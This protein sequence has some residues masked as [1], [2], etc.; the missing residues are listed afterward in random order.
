M[1]LLKDGTRIFGTLYANTEVVIGSM[2]VASQINASFLQANSANVLA[3]AAF[4]KA[5]TDKT[6]LANSGF[7]VTLDENGRLL[8]PNSQSLY[9]GRNPGQNYIVL[10][11]NTATGMTGIQFYEGPNSAGAETFSE[12]KISF[13]T[14]VANTGYAWSFGKNGT[15][16]FPDNTGQ[17]TAFRGFGTDNVARSTANSAS[18]LAQAAFDVANT[19]VAVNADQYARDTA[20]TASANTI[21]TQGVDNTQN[22]NIASVNTFAGSAFDKANTAD[23]KAQ[24]AF[25]SANTNASNINVIQGVNTTQNTNISSV[26]TFA[27]AAYDKA[28]S[29][30]VLAQAAYDKANTSITSDQ[31]ARDTANNASANTIY[32]QGVDVTQNTNIT[33]VN[34]FAGSAYD[35]ANTADVKAQAAFDSA[36]TNASNI[37]I[38]QGIN[39]TQN[40][41]ITNVNTFAGSAYDKANTADVKSQSAYDKANTADVKSQSAYDKANTAAANTVYSQGVNDT[42][43]TSITFLNVYTQAAFDKA[44]TGV[45]SSVDQYARDKANSANVLAQAAFDVANTAASGS[46]DQFARDTANTAAANTVTLQGVNLTQNTAITI[47]QGVD[48]TQNTN[49]TNV[50]T[51]AGSAYDKANTA[52]V[53]AQAA[54]DKANTGVSSSVDQY[55]RDTANTASANTIYTQGVDVTQNTAISVIQGVDLTQNTNIGIIQGVDLTQ[56]AAISVIQGVDLTQNTSIS[57]IQGVDLTQNTRITSVENLVTSSYAHANAAFNQAN[58]GATFVNTGGTVS[59]NVTFTKDVSV[60]GNLY[61]LGNTVSVNTTSFSV[62]D[63]LI[64]LG[65]GNYDTDLLDI[66]FAGHYNDGTNAHAGFIR[67]ASQKEFY[68]FQGY[69]P[70]LSASNNVD[71]NDPSFSKA[72]LNAQVFKGN[73]IGSTAVVNGIELYNYTTSGFAKAN[74]VG[75]LAQASFDAANT[76]AANTVYGQGVNDTQNTN[77]TSVNT[78]AGSAYDKA[79]TADT[80]AQASF[81]V[82]NTNASDIAIIQ[83]VNTTQNT[84]ITNVNTFAGSAY[85]KAN[86]ADVKAQAAFDAANTGG[87][88]GGTLDQYARDKANTASANTIYTQG[89]DL[90]QNTSITFLNAY[91][92]AAF[93]KANTGGAGNSTD[94]YA[95]DTANSKTYTFY[96]NT[97]PATS[98][99]RDLWVNSNTGVVYE[100]FGNT[101]TPIWAEFGPS[102]ISNTS[103]VYINTLDRLSNLSSSLVLN[104]DGSLKF[105]DNTIQA[106]AYTGFGIDNVARITANAAL[107]NTSGTFGGNLTVAGSLGVNTSLTSNSVT[108]NYLTINSAVSFTGPTNLGALIENADVQVSAAP[109]NT[110]I[111][112]LDSAIT[113]YTANSTQNT[114]VNITG[115]GTTTINVLIP[116]GK[117]VSAVLILPQDST[118]YYPNVIQVDGT[119]VTPSWATGTTTI[120]GNPNSTDIYTFT[121][122]KTAD[123]TFKVYASQSKY[124]NIG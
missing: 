65:V 112:L 86:T 38:I 93:D 67:D 60:T 87:G 18:V 15:L 11:P 56:N 101:T 61:V 74:T 88:G 53:K 116:T 55:A 17:T 9:A 110:T 58:V 34:T 103:N 79:N 104:N 119:T 68:I 102:A 37:S 72:N 25:D 27:G 35:K 49:I 50:N 44:N 114:L 75:T 12:S 23:V 43:N 29:A 52:D 84:N 51:F 3:Q 8:F 89:V 123:A 10:V 81:N 115:S 26:N 62:Q 69:T 121:I 73:L 83:G 70:E 100:N 66:G 6:R 94:Q 28:N 109:A 5:N 95:R 36:N 1:A 92:Q 91:T 39:D 13:Y 97:A 107:A 90:T 45:S 40:T 19:A 124:S 42:Q 21:Y 78:F 117:V 59:G 106:T 4:D 77:I 47:L 33:N 63:S 54:F 71:I 111:N 64:V 85:D 22:T 48:L 122:I 16:S 2:N 20:N 120:T 7:T 99:A 76:A 57:V 105:N 30:N 24:A 108:T 118:A 98:N 46:M 31:Y 14:D 41:N 32:T 96:Q 80:K 82:A 113:Y